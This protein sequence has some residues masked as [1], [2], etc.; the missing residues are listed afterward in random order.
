MIGA[1]S[2]AVRGVEVLFRSLLT[3]SLRSTSLLGL[4]NVRTVL[5]RALQTFAC[6]SLVLL[7]LVCPCHP[8]RRQPLGVFRGALAALLR[9]STSHSAS[10]E[11][12]RPSSQ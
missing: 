11:Q 2:S 1:V 5:A 4:R 3:G 12:F 7:W 9:P 8:Q 6:S 10:C